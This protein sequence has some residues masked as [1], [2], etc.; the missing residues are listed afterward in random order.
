M[1]RLA[2]AI[3]RLYPPAWRQRYGPEL[4]DLVARRHIRP[5]DLA[6]LLAGAV[7]ANLHPQLARPMRLAAAGPPAA[8]A[9]PAA[10][11]RAPSFGPAAPI[12][13]GL[14]SRRSF[15]RRMLGVGIGILSLEF[16][17]GTLAFLWP[18]PA[19]G[20]GVEHRVGT[21]LE[22]IGISPEWA[23][24]RPWEFR[25]ARAFLVNVPAA[26]AMALGEQLEVS[27]PAAA[28]ILALWRKCP[29]LGCMIPAACETRDRFQCLCHQ[30]TYNIIGEKLQLGPAPRGM[31]RFPVRIDEHGVVIVDTR[32][33]IK[34][35]PTGTVSFRDPYPIDAG[36]A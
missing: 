21:P 2:R 26:K 30:S 12:P 8:I 28:E 36:C 32:E 25:P 27:S 23:T 24:G 20:I 11:P 4:D 31:D 18:P 19:E 1:H 17:G 9:S 22:I 5:R 35:P 14:I 6:D 13:E 3:L 16:L 7:D 34:G 33:L 10:P 29:H 15:M